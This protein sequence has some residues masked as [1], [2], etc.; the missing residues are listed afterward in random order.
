MLHLPSQEAG[1]AAIRPFRDAES[2]SHALRVTW[3]VDGQV[4]IQPQTPPRRPGKVSL[5]LSFV[6]GGFWFWSVVKTSLEGDCK[7]WYVLEFVYQA[8]LRRG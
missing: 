5:T 7:Q 1:R 8:T 6:T 3:L 2:I 4:R